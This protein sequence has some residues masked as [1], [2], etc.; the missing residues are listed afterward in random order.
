MASFSLGPYQA[1]NFL[2]RLDEKSSIS[3][4][5][6]NSALL[7]ISEKEGRFSSTQEALES[8]ISRADAMTYGV[9]YHSV[10][11]KA[12][13]GRSLEG[14]TVTPHTPSTPPSETDGSSTY[15]M[16][17]NGLSYTVS[18]AKFLAYDAPLGM[19]S[20]TRLGLSSLAGLMVSPF[21]RSPSETPEELVDVQ[22]GR[23][24]QETVVSAS[25]RA[26]VGLTNGSDH[27]F[28][29]ALRQML[30]NVSGLSDHLVGNLSERRYPHLRK[31]A[32]N[33]RRHL[34]GTPMRGMFDVR[35][36]VMPLH[37]QVGQHDAHE[38]LANLFKTVEGA[39]FTSKE[40]KRI[41][42][43]VRG[44]K[45]PLFNWVE[46]TSTY[47]LS[48]L[49]PG[50]RYDSF[51]A[52]GRAG[53]EVSPT[54]PH[55]VTGIF[56]A[57]EPILSLPVAGVGSM[58]NAWNQYCNPQVTKGLDDFGAILQSNVKKIPRGYSD[59]IVRTSEG[60][61]AK[62]DLVSEKTRFKEAPEH[63][64]WSVNRYAY[65]PSRGA[66]KDTTPIS[67]KET[68]TLDQNHI[69]SG[70]ATYRMQAFI[71]HIGGTG[72]GH[73]VGYVR[74]RDQWYRC[75]DTRVTP[76]SKREAEARMGEAYVF[77]AERT[78]HR[79]IPSQDRTE[80]TSPT[81]PE[82]RVVRRRL[83]TTLPTRSFSS[84]QETI[85]RKGH[86]VVSH[87]KADP[88]TAWA[89]G[90]GYLARAFTGRPISESD[91]APLIED[92]QRKYTSHASDTPSLF[93]LYP[94]Y[95]S[96]F[97]GNKIPEAT[98]HLLDADADM[99]VAVFSSIVT[100]IREQHPNSPV[101]TLITCNGKTLALNLAV[102]KSG[103]IEYQIYDPTGEASTYP[104]AYLYKTTDALDAA[105]FL[106]DATPYRPVER[107][108]EAYALPDQNYVTYYT[109]SPAPSSSWFSWPS[110]LT[111]SSTATVVTPETMSEEAIGA[112]FSAIAVKLGLYENHHESFTQA[113][114]NALKKRLQALKLNPEQRVNARALERR[115]EAIQP[116]IYF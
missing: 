45:N 68:F 56:P 37:Q 67:V 28:I 83:A 102:Q 63:L 9:L 16:L 107:G 116:P 29:N 32:E 17:S 13:E 4:A 58:E 50:Y 6:V 44:A 52:E 73:Y 35:R 53:L 74:K 36:E 113:D 59:R 3:V 112:E 1:V 46:R 110:W 86:S 55:L 94:S 19:L 99:R 115:I 70:A 91:I 49:P 41:P 106:K 62:F 85:S 103:E 111:W 82:S 108:L 11:R 79:F 24:V 76:V 114:L 54:N 90:L 95:S 22:R 33:Y 92:N 27:C 20:K 93:E 21:Q 80:S 39:T 31:D 7:S 38:A 66:Y 87:V 18:T 100:G 5:D 89:Q 72:G 97:L 75:D 105:R 12:Q 71:L 98:R 69:Q 51:S 47:D 2:K 60:L 23:S 81:A 43:N 40:A 61:K 14:S 96:S 34:P 65:S 25:E 26:P 57:L 15:E 48:R 88:K 30:H 78:S 42:E 64:L 77:Y 109:F 10:S 84:R 101:G 8:L 104:T